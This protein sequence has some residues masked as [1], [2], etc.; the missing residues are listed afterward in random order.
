MTKKISEKSKISADD[1]S[2][3]AGKSASPGVVLK[4]SEIVVRARAGFCVDGEAPDGRLHLR[5]LGMGEV[6]GIQRVATMLSRPEAELG[7]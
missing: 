7:E 1:T 2:A 3:H 6:R 4:G 5:E